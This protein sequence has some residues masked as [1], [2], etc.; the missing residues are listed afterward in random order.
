MD[1]WA[2]THS[3]L[4]LAF[5]TPFGVT[6]AFTH[7]LSRSET[8]PTLLPSAPR[9]VLPRQPFKALPFSFDCLSYQLLLSKES[10]LLLSPFG[11]SP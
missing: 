9:E 8:L 6:G 1:S 4:W 5:E 7:F 10:T 11:L 2:N 3:H